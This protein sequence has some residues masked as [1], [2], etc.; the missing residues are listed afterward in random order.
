VPEGASTVVEPLKESTSSDPRRSKVT[1]LSGSRG[2]RTLAPRET[3]RRRN[4]KT[5]PGTAG[6]EKIAERAYFISKSAV[7]GSDVENWLLAERQL[8]EEQSGPRGRAK[9]L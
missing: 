8:R 9:S 5:V 7:A 3:P 4:S 6:W 1:G 2:A